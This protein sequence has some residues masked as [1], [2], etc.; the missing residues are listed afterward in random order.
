MEAAGVAVIIVIKL[1][2]GMELGINDLH[3]G[4]P[5][6][7]MGVYG[8]A[9]AV[10]IDAGRTVLMQCNVNTVCEA[11]GG[12]VNGVVHNFPQQVMKPSGRGCTDVHAG[13]HTDCVQTF[14]HLN[15]TCI[16]CL[17][18]SSDSPY[19]QFCFASV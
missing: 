17:G 13:T 9:T 8:H 6:S 3:A 12:F 19:G 4:N 15:I 11:V 10:V 1:A 18:H 14:Q 16:V 5:Q 7:G 2:A